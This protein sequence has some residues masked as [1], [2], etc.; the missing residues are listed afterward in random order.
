MRLADRTKALLAEE[1]KRR[2]KKTPL[3][4]I[5]VREL[6]EACGIDRRTFYYHF[7]DIYDLTAWIFNQAVDEYLAGRNGNT[8]VQSYEKIFSRL[9]KD[10]HFYRRALAEDSQNSLGRHILYHSFSICEEEMK[11]RLGT[12]ALSEKDIFELRYHCY[13]CLGMIRTWFFFDCRPGP[14]QMAVLLAAAMPPAPLKLYD[15]TENRPQ[16]KDGK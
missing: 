3:N 10:D 7:R 12:N 2:T 5:K 14:K 11:R 16:M 4:K 6:C 1:L 13:G 9:Q 15:G 8:A